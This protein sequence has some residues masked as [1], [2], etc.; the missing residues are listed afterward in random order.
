M[1]EAVALFEAWARA[2]LS[3]LPGATLE[4]V[5]LP[6]RTPVIFIEIPGDGAPTTPSCSTAISTSSR[7]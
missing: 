7:R 3:R 2:K 6:G 1:D 5:R 4:V